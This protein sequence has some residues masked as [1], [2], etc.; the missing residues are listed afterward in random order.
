ME[1][2]FASDGN[3]PARIIR[4]SHDW[5]KLRHGLMVVLIVKEERLAIQIFF[6]TRVL[7]IS[8]SASQVKNL[9]P[10]QLRTEFKLGGETKSLC[11]FSL[12]FALVYAFGQRRKPLNLSCLGVYLASSPS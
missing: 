12:Q 10:A 1:A 11:N 8:L 3:M 9:Q 7:G 5:I 4:P 2:V 6:V